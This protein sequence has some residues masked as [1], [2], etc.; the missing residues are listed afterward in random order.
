MNK[1]FLY[2]RLGQDPELR[3]TQSGNSVCNLS[4]AT[5]KSWV[6]KSGQKQSA[7]EWHR[8]VVWGKTGDNC[9]KYLAKGREVII[10]GEL[11]TRSWDDNGT[12]KY[13]TEIVASTVQFVG[14][15]GN[16]A[17][18]GSS[19]EGSGRS[20]P[21]QGS[22]PQNNVPSDSG[23]DGFNE[24]APVGYMPPNLDDIPF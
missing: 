17:A 6:D 13:A 15:N 4:V 16:N 3:H 12:K 24:S 19:S 9:A 18:A 2:G 20:Q 23:W 5:S 8:V 14:S 22:R 21:R 11:Q 1:V 7:T 10:E